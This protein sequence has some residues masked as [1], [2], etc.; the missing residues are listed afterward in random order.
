MGIEPTSEAWEGGS[1][2]RLA[3]P[4]QN[5]IR[6]AYG[7]SASR[8]SSVEFFAVRISNRDCIMMMFAAVVR[9]KKRQRKDR[10]AY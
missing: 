5:A 1:P 2:S 10:D 7:R 9:P 8:V 6:A 4:H 3:A